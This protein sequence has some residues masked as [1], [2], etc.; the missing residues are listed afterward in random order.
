MPNPKPRA[1]TPF[2]VIV[3]A[4][5]KLTM[6]GQLLRGNGKVTTVRLVN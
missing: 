5:L 1:V 4:S 3:Y 6:Q 2:K